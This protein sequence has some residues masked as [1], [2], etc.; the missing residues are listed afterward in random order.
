MARWAATD[1]QYLP[2]LSASAICLSYLANLGALRR[3]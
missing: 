2:E 1:L 3:A